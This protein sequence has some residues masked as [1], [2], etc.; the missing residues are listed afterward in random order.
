MYN[1]GMSPREI[2]NTRALTMTTIETHLAKGYERGYPIDLE[3]LGLTE[4]LY[5][6]ISNRIEE[7]GHPKELKVIKIGLPRGTTYLHIKLAL[8]VMNVRN[9]KKI[10]K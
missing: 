7:M 3:S 8:A 4:Y 5:E 10:E 1:S 6:L 2:A 9:K